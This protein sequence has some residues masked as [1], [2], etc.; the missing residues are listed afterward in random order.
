MRRL[1][2]VLLLA[3]AVAAAT[4]TVLA[5]AEPATGSARQHPVNQSGIS[6]RIDFLDTGAPL[7]TLVVSGRATGLIPGHVYV[8]L[9]YDPGSVSGGPIACE[10]TSSVLTEPQMFV[11]AWTVA[12]NGT[13]TLFAVKSGATYVSLTGFDTISIRDTAI[14][15]GFGPQAVQ[16]CGQ[17][18]RNP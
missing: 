9:V 12:I 2:I 1:L 16:A 3:A 11:G 13:G 10:P 7:D 17:V 8:S 4:S 6:G 15:G 18:S 14:N 5:Q